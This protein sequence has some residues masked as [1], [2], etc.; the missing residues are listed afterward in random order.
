[1]V[2]IAVKA[3]TAYY[4]LAIYD[5]R[6]GVENYC[7]AAWDLQGEPSAMR[8]HNIYVDPDGRA[9]FIKGRQRHYLDEFMRTGAI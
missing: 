3:Y 4:G 7:F 6:H 5:I 2:P 1:M 8:K 9:Y